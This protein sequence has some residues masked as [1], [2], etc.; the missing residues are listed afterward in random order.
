MKY[1]ITESQEKMLKEFLDK[2]YGI[3]FKNA[4]LK[5]REVLARD[6][7]D[8]YP[9]YLL[10]HSMDDWKPSEDWIKSFYDA[11]EEEQYEMALCDDDFTS[12]LY[13]KYI[14]KKSYCW[15]FDDD[16]DDDNEYENEYRYG[17]EIYPIMKYKEDIRNHWLLNYT[18]D[19]EYI[20]DHGF[21]IA[22]TNISQLP[23]TT[24]M[25]HPAE[26]GE[27]GYNFAYDAEDLETYCKSLFSYGGFPTNGAVLFQ[28]SGVKFYH[29]G[30]NENQVVFYNKDAK[31]FIPLYRDDNGWFVKSRLT[32]KPLYRA[33]YTT[34]KND[35]FDYDNFYSTVY[36]RNR[37]PI[38]Q[39]DDYQYRNLSSL[40]NLVN[41]IID[42]FAQYRKHLVK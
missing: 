4:L 2:K 12:F 39:F 15:D 3:P 22:N 40:N 1:I 36:Q 20:A 10:N 17:D 14:L 13:D 25:I 9:D 42:N 34:N 41:W 24:D 11:D 28:A 32:N 30:D 35:K 21:T 8:E 7:F 6:H 29:N 19:A 38:S 23:C 18:S 5:Y 37:R 26:V 33:D 27:E 16:I 31:N